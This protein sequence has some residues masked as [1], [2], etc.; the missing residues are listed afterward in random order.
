MEEHNQTSDILKTLEQEMDTD[1]HPLLKK[2]LDNL[3]PIGITIG[4]I[5][6]AVAVY[7]GVSS[8][9]E[10]RH[11]KAVS[12]L[13]GIMVLADQ[14]ARTEKLQTFAQSGP[15]ELRPAAQLELARI[16]MDQNEFEKAAEAWRSVGQ[17]ADVRVIAG[18]GEAKAR[19]LGGEPAKA[20]EILSALKKDAGEEFAPA[21]SAN[22]AFAAEKAGQTDL[23]IS[24]YEAL[25]SKE[26]GN[27][28]F[29]DYKIGSLK[30]KS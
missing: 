14:A 20:V 3:K 6:T 5:V 7:A 13:G 27:E 25:K 1:I 4:G 28:A 19:I 18:L 15:K 24:E 9:Q 29:L 2:I 10:T 11:E 26:S 30:S 22:L 17:N 16:F 21:I 12:E 8:Y 23:A